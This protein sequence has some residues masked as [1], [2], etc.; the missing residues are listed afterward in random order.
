MVRN[1][2]IIHTAHSPSQGLVLKKGLYTSGNTASTGNFRTDPE[3]LTAHRARTQPRF[4][5]SYTWEVE[6]DVTSVPSQNGAW[7]SPTD[8]L[9]QVATHWHRVLARSLV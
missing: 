5:S 3:L 8:F 7:G 9:A 1:V 6:C 4:L 2:K